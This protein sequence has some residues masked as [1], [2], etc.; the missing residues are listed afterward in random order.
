MT[1][2]YSH[3][4]N[5]HWPIFTCS[6]PI[7][8]SVVSGFFVWLG[9]CLVGCCGF[10]CMWLLVLVHFSLTVKLSWEPTENILGNTDCVYTKKKIEHLTN[11]V[12]HFGGLVSYLT[13]GFSISGYRAF[14]DCK[15]N[16]ITFNYSSN[17]FGLKIS[18]IQH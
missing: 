4:A 9:F 8:W 1:I 7:L 2:P 12:L 10:L 14:V 15:S 16:A 6:C 11:T 5:C 13:L 17:Q 3:K 18:A